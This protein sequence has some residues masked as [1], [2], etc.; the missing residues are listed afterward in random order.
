[1]HKKYRLDYKPSNFLI[2]TTHLTFELEATKTIVKSKIEFYKNTKITDDNTLVLNGE[3]LKLIAIT[4]DNQIPDYQ[5][6]QETL[7]IKNCPNKFTLEITTQI[8]PKKNTSLNGLYQSSNNFC[9][10]CEAEGFRRITYYLDRP[11]VLSVWTTKIIADKSKYPVLLSNG[12]LIKTEENSVTWFD[13]TP[14][15]CYLFALVGGNLAI[16][17]DTFIT[18]S[19]RQIELKIFV[20]PHNLHKTQFAMEALKRAFL[21]DEQRFNLEYD[22]DIFMIVAVDDFNMGA[23]EN[24]GLNIFNSHYVLANQKTATDNDF[25]DVEAVIGHEYFHNWTGNRITC[26]DWF[27]LSLKEGLTVFRDQ[28]FTSDLQNR[29]IKRIDDVR[30]LRSSQFAEDSGPMAH[31]VR[32]E[33]YIEMNNFYTVTIYEKGA[34]IVRM[35]WTILGEEK[36]Q[37]GMSLY[38]K[39]FD[40]QAVT[41]DDFIWAMSEANNYDF[42][43]FKLWYS[44][45]GTPNIDVK[46]TF[47]NNHYSLTFTQ[48]IGKLKPFVIP[49]KY[50]LYNNKGEIIKEDLLILKEQQQTFILEEINQKPIISLLND[51]SAPIKLTTDLTLD[52]KLFLLA[53][54]HNGFNRWDIA[55]E[56]WLEVL[57]KDGK[58]IEKILTSIDEVLTQNTDSAVTAEI[59]TLPSEKELQQHF[60][61]IDIVDIHHRRKNIILNI[62]KRFDWKTIYQSLNNNEVYKF[63]SN[64]IANRRLKNISLYYYSILGEYSLAYKQY[65]QADNMT[66][67]ISALNCLMLENNEYQQLA[68]DDFYQIYQNDVLV[69]DKWFSIQAIAPNSDIQTIKK[70]MSHHK[71]SFK[72][73]NRLRSVIGTFTHNHINFHNEEGYQL[74]TETI[75]KLNQSNPQIGARLV[76]TFNHWKKYIPTLSVLQKQQLQKISKTKDLSKDIYE[77][78]QNALR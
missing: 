69:M 37:K 77:I 24:K 61:K 64:S 8:N 5:I 45:A 70:L 23:M 42:T 17:E 26:Q 41:I 51:F 27:Q 16:L 47:K 21:W 65:Q 46:Q 7:T 30:Y 75:I 59:L 72:N 18:K 44:Q 73:P 13:P 74:F 35:I 54:N 1:M 22:L 71:F 58:I 68:L 20:E 6:N 38:T 31:P 56:L 34:E 78:V 57:T 33:S 39:T 43:Q 32:P 60:K 14:K 12:N 11:D 66:D 4:L 3:N 76:S 2:K 52:D 50:S 53:K 9:T 15:P 67:K 36:F 10:Q 49:I 62:A 63:D 29:T 40:G 55:Q 28:E 19:N 48:N 25:I